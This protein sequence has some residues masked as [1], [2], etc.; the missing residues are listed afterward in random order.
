MEIQSADG[1][2]AH[3]RY[4]K[5]QGY[6]II[7][8]TDEAGRGPLAGPVV[9]AAVILPELLVIPGLNDSKKL[10]ARRRELLYDEIVDKAVAV[11]WSSVGPATID[12]INIYAASRLAMV[13]AIASLDRHFDLVLSDAMPLPDLVAPCI[14]II[15]GDA[16]SAS[17][18]AASIIAKV[19]RDRIMGEM[20]RQYPQYGFGRHKGYGTVEHL[21]ALKKYGPCSIHRQSFAPIKTWR[22]SAG[23]D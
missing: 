5:A 18:A 2:Y 23:E 20:D 6:G 16:L 8:G 1:L 22:F 10:S 13:Q 21:T 9:A 4:W 7:A 12:R 19:T 17:I 3:E 11:A 14:P 15:H